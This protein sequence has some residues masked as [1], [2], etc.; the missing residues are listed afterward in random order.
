MTTDDRK[1]VEAARNALERQAVGHR[2]A[3]E[4]DPSDEQVSRHLVPAHQAEL[5]ATTLGNLDPNQP[6]SRLGDEALY[7]GREALQRDAEGWRGMAAA[8]TSDDWRAEF[9]AQAAEAARHAAGA[10]ELRD[11]LLNRD[12]GGERGDGGDQVAEQEA[13]R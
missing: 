2:Q 11:R 8:A 4:T 10:Q 9:E 5:G 12:H 3:W 6:L 1:V 7:A 13:E